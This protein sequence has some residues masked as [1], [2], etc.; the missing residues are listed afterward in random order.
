MRGLTSVLLSF[1]LLGFVGCEKK[2]V[3]PEPAACGTLPTLEGIWR[4]RAYQKPSDGTSETDPDP[5]GRGVVLTFTEEGNAVRFEGHT[6]ANT[7]SG[8]YQKSD[9]CRLEQ[10]TFGGT[11]V[12]E[13]TEFSSRAWVA[14]N[15]AEA[16]G[17]TTDNLFIYFNS[18]SE[19]MIFDRQH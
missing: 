12:A 3:L 2:D 15:G 18:K 9:S 1:L 14:M 13:P 10:G 11:K 8:G 4:L 19:V 7:V 5:K 6:V 16:Y 17:R